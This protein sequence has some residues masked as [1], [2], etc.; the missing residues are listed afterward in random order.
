MSNLYAL[1]E[2][3]Q[4]WHWLCCAIIFICIDAIA[5]GGFLLGAAV[6]SLV[7]AL[8][9]TIIPGIS[10]QF[11]II[12]FAILSIVFSVL[13]NKLFKDFNETSDAQHINNRAAQMV[14][15]AITLEADLPA[16]QSKLQIG[17]TF[18]T[19]NSSNAH[20]AGERI[21]ISGYDGMTLMI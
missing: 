20:H 13:Y 18:W 16:G 4:A 7:M 15:K 3:L 1:F 11:Q 2:Q 17:D 6:A 14:G 19:V 8:I 5:T 10:W 9:R 21:T 12:V